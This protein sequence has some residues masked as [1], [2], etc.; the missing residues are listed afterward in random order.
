MAE[1]NPAMPQGTTTQTMVATLGATVVK[2]LLMVAGSSLTAHGIISGSGVETF[3][4]VGMVLVG[5]VWSFW[6]S[7]G[8]AIVL[9]KL[10]VWK[11]TALA[12][13]DALKKAN[14]PAPSSAQIA[15]KIPDPGVT[16]AVVAR[17]V[18]T[19]CIALLVLGSLLAA[20]P[21]SAQPDRT[22][23]P[24]AAGKRGIQLPIDPLGLNKLGGGN[25][26]GNDL[27][28]ALEDKLLP[29]LKY[30]LAIARSQ[31][32][33]LTGGCWSAWIAIIEAR[34]KATV[35]EQGQPIPL[36]DPGLITKFQKLVD[37][38]NALQ[39]DSNFMIA[40]SP[41]AS[42]VKSDIRKFIGLI[43]TGGAGLAAMGIGL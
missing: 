31:D 7:Y 18:T 22:T 10:D 34:Q 26:E 23:A 16:A 19:G 1:L 12:Q 21:A 8:R 4:S 43:L 24:S 11:A 39:P 30:A 40:C 20:T 28:G 15:D 17:V 32:N 33:K 13:S 14:V 29:D 3:V 5:A 25:D 9:A 27:L 42:M 36:P 41:V 2:N 38:R 35:D 37:I 6:T